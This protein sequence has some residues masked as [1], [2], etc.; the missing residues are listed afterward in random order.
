MGTVVIF[1][2]IMGVAVVSE[3][4]VGSWVGIIGG[5]VGLLYPPKNRRWACLQKLGYVLFVGAIATLVGA[6]IATRV[7][8]ASVAFQTLI[9]VGVFLL[10]GHVIVGNACRRA[11]ENLD[12]RQHDRGR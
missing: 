2:V 3:I 7:A 10:V 1:A 8:M 12:Q 4:L 5:F 9:V 6:W 11:H